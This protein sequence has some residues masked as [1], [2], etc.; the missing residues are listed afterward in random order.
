MVVH[1]HKV[2]PSVG[3]S[4]TTMGMVSAMGIPINKKGVGSMPSIKKII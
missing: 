4:A 2:Y 3:R 1:S